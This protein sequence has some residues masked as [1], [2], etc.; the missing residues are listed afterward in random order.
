M[1]IFDSEVEAMETKIRGT[2]R[3]IYDN[4][5]AWQRVQIARHVQRPFA[6]DYIERCFTDWIELHGDRLFADDKAMPCGLARL[7][8]LPLRRDHASERPQHQRKCDAQFR[9]RASGRL[10]QGAAPDAP[11]GEIWHADYFADR[12]A[13]APIPES[14]RR[15]AT[16]R[17][18]SRS[19]CAK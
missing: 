17:K 5:T 14:A 6:L 15:S 7:G 12:H 1:S 4:L 18:R 13:R 19:I 11:G 8:P 9:L 16:F 2:R 3:E 10:S